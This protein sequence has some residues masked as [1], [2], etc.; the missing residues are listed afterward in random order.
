MSAI[1]GA[2]AT[3]RPESGR[4]AAE[5]PAPAKGLTG[6]LAAGA[7]R[8]GPALGTYGVVK[9]SGFLVF[10]WL[11]HFSGDYRKKPLGMGYGARPWDVLGTWDARSYMD[12]ATNGYHPQVLPPHSGLAG[13]QMNT[14]AFFP[15]YPAVMRAVMECTG[16]GAY[17]AGV[18]VA[19]VSSFVAAAGIFA[20]TSLLGGARAGVVAAGLWALVPGSGVE[21]AVYSD[22]LYVAVAAWALYHLMR[23]HWITA[24]LLTLV[25]GFNRPTSAALIAAVGLA[26]LIAL[27]QRRDGVLRPLTAMLIAPW[28]FV[29]YLLWVGVKMHNLGGYFMIQRVWQH[30]FDYGHFTLHAIPEIM[31]GRYHYLWPFALADMISLGCLIMLPILLVLLLRKRPPLALVV[32]T[33]LTIASTVLNQQIFAN[34]PRYLLPAFPL[35]IPLAI[36]MRRLKWPSLATV[37]LVLGCA[38]GWYAGFV[39]F[40]LGTP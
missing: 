18:L 32:Y 27:F 34:I 6:R 40:E 10:M 26:A 13:V 29:G 30:Y 36:G 23:R 5:P 7:R 12:I 4:D 28:G 37:L 33:L 38:A 3:D 16:L 11:L 22:S 19:V 21:W 14:A 2:V 24:G 8:F 35:L 39:T 1:A 15:L 25:S 17:G 20:V 31:I 9:L